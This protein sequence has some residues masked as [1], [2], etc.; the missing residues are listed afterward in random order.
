M[1]IYTF[2]CHSLSFL[3]FL[4]LLTGVTSLSFSGQTL[5]NAEL[6][7][8]VTLIWYIQDAIDSFYAVEV[9][10]NTVEDVNKLHSESGFITSSNIFYNYKDI[11]HQRSS[12]YY[13]HTGSRVGNYTG[14]FT[15]FI[16]NLT[17]NDAGVYI[18][19]NLGK[20]TTR[21]SLVVNCKFT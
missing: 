13:N 16:K 2:N 8:S 19:R 5:K 3:L 21:T 18:L 11:N 4:Y 15:L 14:K 12:V 20:E 10:I 17:L 9:F 7:G 1:L 6:H